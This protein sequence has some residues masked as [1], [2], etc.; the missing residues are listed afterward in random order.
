[1]TWAS[2]LQD[3]PLRQIAHQFADAERPWLA[4]IAGAHAVDQL[5][6]LRRRDRDDVVALVRK[7]LA[8]RVAVLYRCE[9]GAEEQRKTVGI[10]VHRPDGLRHEV[11]GVTA[12][13]ADRGMTVEHKTVLPLH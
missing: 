11:G 7:A 1:M 10:L 5:A 6:E 13:L 8:R 4:L 2:P 3:L 9:H 12:D